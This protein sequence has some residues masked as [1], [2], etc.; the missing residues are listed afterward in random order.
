MMMRETPVSQ[1]SLS[2]P[3][4][5]AL[6]PCYRYAAIDTLHA[7]PAGRAAELRQV[8][9]GLLAGPVPAADQG[10]TQRQ[11]HAGRARPHRAHW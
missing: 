1:S 3:S 7:S 9:G 8:D 4:T 2:Y 10:Q 11:H 5:R 6:N